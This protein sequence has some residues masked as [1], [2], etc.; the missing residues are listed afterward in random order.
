MDIKAG[1][2]T[3][4]VLSVIG[5]V[6][7]LWMGV[8][9]IQKGRKLLYFRLRQQLIARG[10]SLIFSSLIFM[11][12]AMF[13]SQYAEPVIYVFYKPSPT[14]TITATITMTPT[15][16]LTPTITQT[17][18][19]TETPS[20]T[21][22]PLPSPTPSIPFEVQFNFTSEVSPNP[23]VVFSPLVFSKGLDLKTYSPIGESTSF[24]YPIKKVVATFSYDGMST[25][26]Q[27]SVL[28]YRNDELVHYE[29][30]EWQDDIG[31]YGFAELDS[32]VANLLPGEYQAQIFVGF[33]WMTVGSFTIEGDLP[34]NTPTPRPTLLPTATHTKAPTPTLAPSDTR[35]PTKAPTSTKTPLPTATRQLTA[36]ATIP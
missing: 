1:V 28:W 23:E 27:W 19:I 3:A 15:I 4:L 26:V 31:G 25:G 2:T 34:T 17:P 29:T 10:W 33:D 21:E 24:E 36:T 6:A 5:L 22:T 11:A 30:L 16:T 35:V 20:V 18:T 8:R 9:S 13:F 7:T 12:S 32:S 14:P